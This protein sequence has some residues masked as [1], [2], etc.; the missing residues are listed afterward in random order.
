MAAS[1]ACVS[2]PSSRRQL[3]GVA[4]ITAGGVRYA[5]KRI[6]LV[7]DV[8]DLASGTNGVDA[9]FAKDLAARVVE[10]GEAFLASER[11]ATSGVGAG[12]SW[13]GG[14]RSGVQAGTGDGVT[15]GRE[16]ESGGPL[17]LLVVK[18]YTNSGSAACVR[19]VWLG[20]GDG[21]RTLELLLVLLDCG[22]RHHPLLLG[23]DG[24][25]GLANACFPDPS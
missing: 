20:N 18:E 3:N 23:V 9:G 21:V 25:V 24:V 11:G 17:V 14:L 1:R 22:R 19:T 10:G 13:S 8:N 7:V 2:F 6:R 16:V 5:K 15:G 12:H 4:C